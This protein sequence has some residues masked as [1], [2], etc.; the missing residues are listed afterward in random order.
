M[1]KRPLVLLPLDNIVRT[2][3]YEKLIEAYS[4]FRSYYEN[5]K[6]EEGK[7]EDEREKQLSLFYKSP[8][9]IISKLDFLNSKTR[10]K[11]VDM[12][13][14][15]ESYYEFL[16]FAMRKIYHFRSLNDTE[17]SM[18][19]TLQIAA[20]QICDV[21]F[22]DIADIPHDESFLKLK[23]S[24]SALDKLKEL[25][26]NKGLLIFHSRQE[27]EKYKEES[28]NYDFIFD[29]EEWL[30]ENNKTTIVPEE[31]FKTSIIDIDE[32]SL[33]Q[34]IEHNVLLGFFLKLEADIKE[35]SNTFSE[36]NTI[37]NELS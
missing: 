13:Y 35:T 31:D 37:I 20:N 1:H 7:E 18:V 9:A 5:Y 21:C 28:F 26:G 23:Y 34:I 3:T 15:L 32:F 36:D 11:I 22:Y 12:F 27:F 25:R 2:N 29:A 4:E 33:E 30:V 10:G 24:Y 8:L 14:D 17:K 16:E 6:L 19:I